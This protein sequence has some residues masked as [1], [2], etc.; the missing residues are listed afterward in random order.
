MVADNEILGDD[1]VVD[2]GANA[3]IEQIA[4]GHGVQ[5]G[6]PTAKLRD[7]LTLLGPKV[8]LIAERIA[9]L[10]EENDLHLIAFQSSSKPRFV[11]LPVPAQLTCVNTPREKRAKGDPEPQPRLRIAPARG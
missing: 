10:S 8:F 5:F 1:H 4:R 3:R 7:G 2:A 11:E 6:N 9:Q